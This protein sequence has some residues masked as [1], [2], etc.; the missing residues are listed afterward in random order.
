MH[1]V[2]SQWALTVFLMSGLF[3]YLVGCAVATSFAGVGL[4]GAGTWAFAP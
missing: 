3:M 2:P 4:T 1:P